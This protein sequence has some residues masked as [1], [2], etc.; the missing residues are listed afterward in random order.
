[1][2][3]PP[4]SVDE[5]L[6]AVPT[7]HRVALEGLRATIHAIVPDAVEVISYGMPAYKY[8]GRMLVG[9]AAFTKHC[10][11]ILWSGKTLEHFKDAVEGYETSKSTVHF[12]LEKPLPEELV[13][14]LVMARLAEN[15]T[16]RRTKK[17]K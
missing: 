4:K 16:V 9:F 13:R 10:S 2:K 7:Q 17:K 5:Y 12:T 6:A 15:E 14:A 8:Q 3:T 11:L 1:M